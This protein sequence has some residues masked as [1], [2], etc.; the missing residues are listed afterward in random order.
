MKT[1]SLFTIFHF[2]WL[3]LS[4]SLKKLQIKTLPRNEITERLNG[5]GPST[6]VSAWKLK[7]S[8]CVQLGQFS[9]E[10]RAPPPVLKSV[11]L[12]HWAKFEFCPKR[13]KAK[14]ENLNAFCLSELKLEIFFLLHGK[15]NLQKKIYGEKRAV[16]TRHDFSLF[17][18]CLVWISRFTKLSIVFFACFVLISVLS[19]STKFKNQ[20][21]RF[22]SV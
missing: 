11:R 5:S 4:K 13:F 16:S 18:F 20:N 9:I 1:T 12:A 15:S 10:V 7:S 22:C 17:T 3:S 2:T 6:R 8:P 14:N 21:M 19:P